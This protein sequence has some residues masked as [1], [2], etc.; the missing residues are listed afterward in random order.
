MSS[1]LKKRGPGRFLV[2]LCIYL[3]PSAPT[4]FCYEMCEGAED[5]SSG[6]QVF[7][8]SYTLHTPCWELVYKEVGWQDLWVKTWGAAEPGRAVGL[9]PVGMLPPHP[10]LCLS[11]NRPVPQAASPRALNPQA[12]FC[13]LWSCCDSVLPTPC[14]VLWSK[15]W[16]KTSCLVIC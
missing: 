13:S 14:K 7:F 3:F 5:V 8:I 6:F 12:A 2:D 9:S 15:D 10:G 16:W 4:W 1:S 11:L